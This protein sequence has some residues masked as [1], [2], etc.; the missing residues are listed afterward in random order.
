[1]ICWALPEISIKSSLAALDRGL[2]AWTFCS[3][4]PKNWINKILQSEQT[5]YCFK[6]V[7]FQV[8]YLKTL[9]LTFSAA[10]VVM[11]CFADFDVMSLCV[12]WKLWKQVKLN[13]NCKNKHFTSSQDAAW[14]S[15]RTE[16]RPQTIARWLS[17]N[18][19]LA[20]TRWLETVDYWNETQSKFVCEPKD[21][22]V[23]TPH[24]PSA[25]I[26]TIAVTAN[27]RP[28]TRRASCRLESATRG[29]LGFL[30][31]HA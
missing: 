5:C 18:D 9:S 20:V 4:I 1:M 10:I 11:L 13:W 8:S 28:Q 14:K 25:H 26:R 29:N 16:N 31:S 27:R 17:E 2:K 24:W 19:T 3:G 21:M 30:S 23:P 12:K 22:L 6:K 7:Q 15:L